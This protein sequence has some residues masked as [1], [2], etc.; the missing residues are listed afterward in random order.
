MKP[1]AS[2]PP[3]KASSWSALVRSFTGAGT[4]R[5]QELESL[6]GKLGFSQTCLFG[7]FARIQLRPLYRKLYDRSFSPHLTSDELSNL[8]WRAD[9]LSELNPRIPRGCQR[10]PDWVL[11][12]DAATSTNIFAAVLF[13]G[14]ARRNS[15]VFRLTSGKVPACWLSRFHRREKIYGPDLLPPLA[16]IWMYGGGASRKFESK[17]LPRQRQLYSFPNQRFLIK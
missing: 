8:A 1:Q 3:E 5:F 17:P 11:F 7:E 14:G 4:I 2:L 13:R 6:V 10:T 9:V 12:T 15:P 16:F